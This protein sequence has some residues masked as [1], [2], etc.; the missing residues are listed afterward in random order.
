MN[1]GSTIHSHCFDWSRIAVLATML[2]ANV[3]LSQADLV[4]SDPVQEIRHASGV[5]EIAVGFAYQNVGDAPITI[6]QLDLS[7]G[8][9]TKVGEPESAILPKQKGVL[10]VTFELAARRRVQSRSIT[11]TTDDNKTTQLRVNFVL[12]TD[13]VILKPALL[14]WRVG[15]KAEAK[16][17]TVSIEPKGQAKIISVTSTSPRILT[18]LKAVSEGEKYTLSVQPIATDKAETAQVLLQTSYPPE[19]PKAYTVNVEI[20]QGRR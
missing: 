19:Q 18:A 7:C 11:V 14:V 16:Q 5:K 4:W 12:D 15:Q 13:P 6:V 8:S 9:C 2:I 17:V 20:R 10:P 1:A 3:R